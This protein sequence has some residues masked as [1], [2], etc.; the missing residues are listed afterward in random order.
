MTQMTNL[1]Q[2]GIDQFLQKFISLQYSDNRRE[3]SIPLAYKGCYQLYRIVLY[4]R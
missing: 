4:K 1:A 3:C 2:L